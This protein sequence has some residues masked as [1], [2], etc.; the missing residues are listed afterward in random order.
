M[1]RG[2]TPFPARK[3]NVDECFPLMTF[4]ECATH[5]FADAQACRTPCDRLPQL[6]A[7]VWVVARPN[8][9]FQ[10]LAQLAVHCRRFL[11]NLS[12]DLRLCLGCDGRR[13]RPNHMLHLIGGEHGRTL[14][15]R[16]FKPG[17]DCTGLR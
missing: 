17:S 9:T 8:V 10:L 6:S 11:L 16:W 12:H 5:T 7:E 13:H 3:K 15:R 4:R 1:L 14:L 2:V